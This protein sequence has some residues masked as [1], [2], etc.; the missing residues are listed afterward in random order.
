MAVA[1]RGRPRA[2]GE[3]PG[4]RD[5]RQ[6]VLGAAAEL[7]VSHGYSATSTRSIAEKAGLRQA[8]LY[9]YFAGKEDILAELL[10]GTVRPSLDYA[11]RL[12]EK[13]AEDWAKLWALARFDIGLLCSGPVNLGA[14][15]LLPEIGADRFAAFRR[16]RAELKAIY[17]GLAGAGEI[18][19]DLLFGLVESVIIVRREKPPAEGFAAAGADAALRVAG[20]PETRLAEMRSAGLALCP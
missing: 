3:A 12:S 1:S 9:H 19:G 5:S 16:E 13:A 7:F 15:Y 11:A 17:R 2:T 8:S 20:C 10:A 6:D 14:L 18:T 4:E